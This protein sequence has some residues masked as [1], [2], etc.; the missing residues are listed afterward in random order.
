MRRLTLVL[1]VAALSLTLGGVA[2]AHVLKFGK[3]KRLA[4]NRADRFAGQQTTIDIIF[5][6]S[7]HRFYAEAEWTRVNPTGCQECVWDPSTG[8]LQPSPTTEYCH[9][10][11]N[12]R[13]K[14]LRS[15]S[16][17]RRVRTFITSSDCF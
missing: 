16:A 6:Q 8:T 14:S 9:V 7:A 5:R 3:A 10:D 17:S 4:Q 1:M 12:I 11:L 15:H 2:D 13:F